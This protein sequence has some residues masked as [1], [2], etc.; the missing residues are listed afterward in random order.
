M[1][2]ARSEEI[3]RNGTW[4]KT[5]TCRVWGRWSLRSAQ[6]ANSRGR[7]DRLASLCMKRPEPSRRCSW[8]DS[9][10]RMAGC[11]WRKQRVGRTKWP[12]GA[13]E[14]IVSDTTAKTSTPERR[15]LIFETG[16]A[17]ITAT[18]VVGVV[19]TENWRNAHSSSC[20]RPGMSGLRKR[21]LSTTTGRWA[22]LHGMLIHTDSDRTT[23]GAAGTGLSHP[24]ITTNTLHSETS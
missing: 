19:S 13:P 21:E 6:R 8:T 14:C 18:W 24:D 16:C 15:K 7:P 9:I 11:R 3:T 20:R 22:V 17:T 4:L 5:A 12:H 1:T 23:R 2:R 10:R